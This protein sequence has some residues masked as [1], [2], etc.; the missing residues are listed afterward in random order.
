MSKRE[1][2]IVWTTYERLNGMLFIS[3]SISNSDGQ[4][5][6]DGNRK[7]V[8]MTEYGF[9]FLTHETAPSIPKG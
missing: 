1:K 4:L 8:E 2:I 9:C 5:G 6:I 7:L 3:F